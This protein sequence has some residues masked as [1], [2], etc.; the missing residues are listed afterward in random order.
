[1][2]L[3]QLLKAVFKL[4]FE[5]RKVLVTLP[6]L[7][8]I[9]FSSAGYAQMPAKNVDDIR[10]KPEAEVRALFGEP[11]SVQGPA[12]THATYMLW[13]YGDFT[14]A[15]ANNRAFHLFNKNNSETGGME[16]LQGDTG[17]ELEVDTDPN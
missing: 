12:G 11:M 13:K 17:D 2:I 5:V 15:F 14:V 8:V 7:V 1:M 4:F 10:W 16:L 9:L 3:N 6:M